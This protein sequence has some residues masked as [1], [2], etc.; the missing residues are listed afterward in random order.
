MADPNSSDVLEQNRALNEQVAASPLPTIGEI[1]RDFQRL[2][3][4]VR[5]TRILGV[6][7]VLLVAFSIYLGVTA[8]A[9]AAKAA[10]AQNGLQVTC[11]SGNQARATERNLW[12][13]L[14]SIPA[15]SPET[16]AQQAQVAQFKTFLNLTLAPRDCTKIAGT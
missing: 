14:F 1:G 10:R 2:R 7:V 3:T 11:I 15:T 5:N 8:N 16:P 4:A 6:V 12:N 9:A 13:Y